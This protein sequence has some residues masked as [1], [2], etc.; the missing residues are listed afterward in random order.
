[1]QSFIRQQKLTGMS[2]RPTNFNEN[3]VQ[4]LRRLLKSKSKLSCNTFS[5]VQILHDEIIRKTNLPLSIQ[6]LNRFFGLVSNKFRPSLQTLD[7]LSRYLEY[8]S[9]RNFQLLNENETV[10]KVD[11]NHFISDFFVSLFS[12]LSLANEDNIEHLVK[13]ILTW[14]KKNPQL[15]TQIYSTVATTDFGR[16][17]FFEAFINMDALNDGFGKGLALLFVICLKAGAKI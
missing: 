9:F 12:D 14:M 10:L 15:T 7:I 11:K 17:H 3:A 6:T 8:D 2:R 4:H 13:N 16:K 1:M 5:D